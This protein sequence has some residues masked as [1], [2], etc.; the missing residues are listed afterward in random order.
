MPVNIILNFLRLEVASGIILFLMTLLAMIFVNSPLA[1]LYQTLLQIP[2]A[3]QVG[4]FSFSEPLLFWINECLMTIFFLIVGLELKR[5]FLEGELSGVTKIMLPGV[6]ALGGML[7]PAIIYIFFN[8]NSNIT[9]RGWAIPVATDIAFALGVLSLFS[10]RIPLGLKLFLMALAIFDD[11]GAI[12]IIAVF[13]SHD[14]S[15]LYLLFACLI[16]FFLWILNHII[17]TR[18][19]FPYL[20]LG[21]LLWICVLH[22]GIHASIAGVLLS[23]M[24]PLRGNS[25]ENRSPLH[26]LEEV[27]H[28]WVAYFV[29]PLFAFANSGLSFAGLSWNSL[30]D[31]LV[32]G[33][34]AGLFLGKQIGVLTLVWLMV[35]LRWA[36]LPERATWLQMYG[37][38]LLCGIGF[39]MSLF[40]G[41]LAFQT[42]QAVYLTEVRLGVLL[43][44]VL[45]GM[46]GAAVLQTAH[47]KKRKGRFSV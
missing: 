45:S 41:T 1:P 44:S 5:E 37:V 30:L 9:L 7:I 31:P 33:I 18:H 34:I 19:L 20:F 38:A 4:D 10:K 24:I 12:I 28:P 6:A 40:L 35:K 47:L 23:L 22:S 29:L 3:I 36:K 32:L 21:V 14:L 43:G 2:L 13:Y 15:L 42:E 8:Y 16:V 17:N 46:A 26:T 39:T 25:E 27:L 11:V